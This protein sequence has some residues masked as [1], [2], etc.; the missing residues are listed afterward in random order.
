MM[1]RLCLIIEMLNKYLQMADQ[2]SRR[3]RALVVIYEAVSAD[4]GGGKA[5]VTVSVWRLD[6]CSTM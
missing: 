5:V 2:S 6:A 3:H 4:G 1:H